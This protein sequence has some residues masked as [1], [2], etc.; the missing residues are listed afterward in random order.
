VA[1]K[2]D[3]KS[4]VN[5]EVDSADEFQNGNYANAETDSVEAMNES[6]I[7]YMWGS[8]QDDL[9]KDQEEEK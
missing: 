9:M 2:D 6:G 4:P 5:A 3:Y 7:D 1:E 8:D